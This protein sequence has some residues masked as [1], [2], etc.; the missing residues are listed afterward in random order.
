MSQYDAATN[1]IRSRSR[2][3]TRRMAGLCTRPADRPRFTFRHSTGDTSQ[4]Y[5]A[6]EDAA[7]LG[8][9]DQAVVD[10]AGVGHG[11]RRWPTW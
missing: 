11:V 4:P 5:E 1:A 2:S 8:R 9:V 7:G 10:L 6:V 3:T